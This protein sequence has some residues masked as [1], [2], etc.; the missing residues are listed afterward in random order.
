MVTDEIIWFWHTYQ[1]IFLYG[2]ILRRMQLVHTN[3]EIEMLNPYSRFIM[4]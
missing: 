4:E 1:C 3:M 2:L